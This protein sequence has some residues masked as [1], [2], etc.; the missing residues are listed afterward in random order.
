[1]HFLRLV[2]ITRKIQNN[3]LLG[4]VFGRTIFRGFLFLGRRIFSRILSPDFFSFLWEKV[5]RK[6][7]QE[8]PRQNPPK[9]IQQKSPTHFCRRAGPTFEVKNSPKRFLGQPG[10]LPTSGF[11]VS[12]R[13]PE[14][15]PAYRDTFLTLP[16][17]T[18][19]AF[20]AQGLV[21]QCSATP[22]T[23]AA[24]PPCS[25]TPFQTQISVRHLPAQGGGR[26]DTKIFRGCSATPV[27]HPQNAIKS[28]NAAA[29]RVARHV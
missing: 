28:R 16:G 6:I 15:V 27:L 17:H 19:D 4:S 1:M 12:K 2:Q 8:N 9:V 22:A 10:P 26:C 5:P 13:C 7:L 3:L 23:V 20:G 21:A 29:T 18:W 11:G 24:T 14:S 25:A